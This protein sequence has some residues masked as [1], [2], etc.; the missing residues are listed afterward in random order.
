M[1]LYPDSLLGGLVC[2]VIR[3]NRAQVG[4]RSLRAAFTVGVALLL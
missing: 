2:Y 3:C 1:L 4:V